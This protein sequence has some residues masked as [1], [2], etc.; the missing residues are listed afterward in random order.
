ML[1]DSELLDEAR[2]APRLARPGLRNRIVQWHR[3]LE[4]EEGDR[5]G[6][7]FAIERCPL[8]AVPLMETDR[9][10]PPQPALFAIPADVC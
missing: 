4:L 3:D 9:M 8:V 1:F 7:G 6:D 5:L 10:L 2:P